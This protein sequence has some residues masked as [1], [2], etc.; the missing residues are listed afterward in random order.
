M[1][2]SKA[3]KVLATHRY[4]RIIGGE[5]AASKINQALSM[6]IKGLSFLDDAMKSA[7]DVAPELDVVELMQAVEEIEKVI[8]RVKR[9][10]ALASR[11]A[12]EWST[13]E[14][15]RERFLTFHPAVD[16]GL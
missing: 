7:E 4:E 16:N 5:E 10:E 1:E 14:E 3:I 9:A 2:I 13:A 8:A 6:G 11:K 12:P 15:A